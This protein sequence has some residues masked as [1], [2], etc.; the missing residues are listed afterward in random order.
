MAGDRLFR[1]ALAVA[2]AALV[3]GCDAPATAPPD[4]AYDPTEGT[5][6]LVFHWAPGRTI[7]LYVDETS[8]SD[9]LD[10]RDA[11]ARGAA[12]W[13]QTAL[14]D[15]FSFRI[16]DDPRAADVVIHY[17][18]AP[19]I[20]L[21]PADCIPPGTG[22]ALTVFCVEE[23][24]APVLPLLDGGGG[25]VKMDVYL[26][27]EGVETG[28]LAIA[29]LT[30]QEYFV[31]LAAHELGHVLGLGTHSPFEDDI[32]RSVPIVSR[33]SRGDAEALRWVLARKADIRL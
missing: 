11:V 18:D 14:F 19:R 8:Q 21:V 9:S 22:D 26:D 28:I 4:P 15:E 25:R 7:S 27:P 2:A 24:E 31:V 1:R 23:P 32:M 33:P 17:E 5:A 13:E 6:G 10:I 29:G 3:A 16:V 30:R 12:L 20:V